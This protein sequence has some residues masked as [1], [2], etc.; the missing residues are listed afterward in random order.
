MKEVTVTVPD[1]FEWDEYLYIFR[2]RSEKVTDNADLTNA[3]VGD[4][5]ETC[6]NEKAVLVSTNGPKNCRFIF[7]I[8]RT[9]T[10]YPC[11]M[12]DCF[13]EH[14]FGAGCYQKYYI[15]KK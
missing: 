13:D 2:E 14:G 5:Y 11:E 4:V 12:P 9:D 15:R 3:K 1:N 6:L 7:L 8:T 10:G